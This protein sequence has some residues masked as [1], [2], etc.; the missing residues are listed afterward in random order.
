MP[1]NIAVTP[2]KVK[3]II[4]FKFTKRNQPFAVE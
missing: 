1:G 4:S 2:G 3:A